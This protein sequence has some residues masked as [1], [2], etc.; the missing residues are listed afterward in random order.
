MHVG[1]IDLRFCIAVQP[2][3]NEKSKKF[4]FDIITGSSPAH[5]FAAESR[6][7]RD[8][9]ITA[10]NDFL[11]SKKAVSTACPRLYSLAS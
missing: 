3:G 2:S 6:Q 8:D 10:L 11:F 1:V 9:W 7:E 5:H 4:I